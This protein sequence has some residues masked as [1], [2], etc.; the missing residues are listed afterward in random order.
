[1]KT[2]KDNKIAIGVILL[3]IVFTLLFQKYG[4]KEYSRV[5]SDSLSYV[6]GKVIEITKE[7]LEYNEKLKISQGEQVLKIE[8]LEGKQKGKIVEINNYLTVSHNVEAK[9]N[10]R[11]VV[12]ADEPDQI[13]PY[14]TVYNYD[15]TIGIVGFVALFFMVIL[16]IGRGKGLKAII[17]LGY[18]LYVVIYLVIPAV[19]SGYSPIGM[20]ILCVILSTMVTLLLLNG[21]SVKTYGAILSTVLGVG[22]SAIV[23]FLMSYVFKVNGFSTDEAESLVLIGESTGLQIKE[24]LFAGILISSLGAVMDVGMSIVSSLYEIDRHNSDL[25]FAELVHS[26][27]EI[28]KDMIGTMC[29]TLIL[30]FTGS[31]FVTLLV[32]ISYEVQ[33]KQILNSNYMIIEIAQGIAGTLGIVMTVPIASFVGAYLLGRKK[34]AAS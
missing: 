16:A 20:S 32:F 25:S 3:T 33:S 9:K 17:G 5:N 2:V 23:F 19:F 1:M 34:S 21:N 11:I 4:M 8:L 26:G 27:L 10:M 29:N 18:S 22:V 13:E 30:A 28:G 12:C 15:R 24:I 6:K 31:S 14:Y 7:S